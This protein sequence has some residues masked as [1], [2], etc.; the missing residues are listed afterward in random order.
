MDARLV[1]NTWRR[2][3]TDDALVHRVLNAQAVPDD[4]GFSSE[5]IEILESYAATPVQ[6]DINIGMYRSGLV[7]NA[8]AAMS[9]VPLSQQLLYASGLE[10]EA[11]AAGYAEVDCYADHGPNFWRAAGGFVA[12]LA[13]RPEFAV[14]AHQEVLALDTATIALAQRLGGCD[15]R[16]FGGASQNLARLH[17]ARTRFS[18]SPAATIVR[19]EHDLTAWIV[20]PQ[21]YDPSELLP[22]SVHHWLVYFPADEGD[23]GYAEVSERAARMFQLLSTPM[24]IADLALALDGVSHADVGEILGSLTALGVVKALPA[25]QVTMETDRVAG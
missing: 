1:W 8:L 2:I 17:R 13:K 11:V 9:L 3:L 7:R 24:R 6:T 22:R 20:N 18:A 5:E 4:T 15:D 25:S 12:Y 10:V 23:R 16:W 21:D 19:S 14:P